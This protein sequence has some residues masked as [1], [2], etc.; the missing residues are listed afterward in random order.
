MGYS[1]LKHELELLEL[2][3]KHELKLLEMKQK[4]EKNALVNSCNHIY[5]DGSNAGTTKG[6]QR[7]SWRVCSICNKSL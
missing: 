6:D 1:K 3:H 5:E 4:N 7:E 2:N